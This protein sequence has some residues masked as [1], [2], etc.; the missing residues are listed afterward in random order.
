[1]PKE[2]YAQFLRTYPVGKV[3]AIWDAVFEMCDLFQSTAVELSE[4]MGFSYDYVKAKNCL[5]FLEHVRQL[6]ADVEGVF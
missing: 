4:N 3:E 1:M 6:P 5:G 2:K